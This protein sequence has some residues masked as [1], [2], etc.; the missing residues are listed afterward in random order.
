M[1]CVS[2]AFAGAADGQKWLVDQDCVAVAC[3]SSAVS[4]VC[5]VSFDPS[6][7]IAS[8]TASTTG[9]LTNDIITVNRSYIVPTAF[10]E[11]TP[12]GVQLRLG[13]SIYFS[14]SAAQQVLLYLDP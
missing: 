10:R 9:L 8:L 11:N 2:M 6:R 13:E 7:T 14:A 5:V 12:A 1:R 3:I 4:G